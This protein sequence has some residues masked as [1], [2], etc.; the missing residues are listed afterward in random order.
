MVA[1]PLIE[2]ANDSSVR[3]VS[4]FREAAAAI[5][6]AWLSASYRTEVAAAPMRSESDK[7]YFVGHDG[8]AGDG[9][10]TSR[11]EEYLAVALFNG[12]GAESSGLALPGGGTIRIL[13]YQVP[14]K[15]KQDDAGVGKAD[16]MAVLPDNRLAVVE[17]KYLKESRSASNAD[18]PLRALLEGLAYCAFFDADLDA[19][20]ADAKRNFKL[21]A[22]PSAPALVILANDAYWEAYRNSSPAG[23]WTPA[24]DRLADEAEKATGVAISFLSLL[25]EKWDHNGGRPAFSSTPHLEAAW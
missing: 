17:L 2:M 8:T 23:A 12:A 22:A 25:N 21:D 6:G 16:L 15:A 4:G 5:D 1:H 14:L 7:Y 19:L 9:R 13:D 18:T 11:S 24:M 10:E 20:R 3:S